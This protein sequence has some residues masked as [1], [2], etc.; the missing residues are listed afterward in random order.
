VVRRAPSLQLTRDAA[1]PAARMN[2]ATMA[3]IGLQSG[4]AVR[5][6]RS[7]AS[8]VAGEA[9]LDAVLDVSVADGT[10]RIAAAHEATA[11]LGA[12]FGAVTVERA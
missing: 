8:G 4:D 3:R 11:G 9:L 10:V 5:V 7:A 2:A 6:R 12:M 1:P